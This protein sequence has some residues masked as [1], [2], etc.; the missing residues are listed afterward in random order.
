MFLKIFDLSKIFI[1]H[2]LELSE[3]SPFLL[4]FMPASAV[5]G[6]RK[7]IDRCLSQSVPA[8]STPVSAAVK[9]E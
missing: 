1:L 4:L 3:I 5:D 7:M 2:I 9:S 6:F 8:R